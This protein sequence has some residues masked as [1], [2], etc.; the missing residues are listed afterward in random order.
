MRSKPHTLITSLKTSSHINPIQTMETDLTNPTLSSED[1]EEDVSRRPKD[2]RRL[3][4]V[5]VANTKYPVVRYVFRKILGFRLVKDDAD[6]NCDVYW[7][8]CCIDVEKL[9]RL[10][11]FQ[12]IN[13]FPGM[14]EIGRKNNLARNLNRM[15]K[16]F[17]KDYDFYPRTWQ[18][19]SE[20]PDFA[21]QFTKKHNKTF[22]VKPEA[23][24]QGR[25]IFL[26]RRLEDIERGERF[27]A[28]RYLHRP[29]LLDGLKFDL[30][31]YVLVA[32][33][34]PLRIY[35]HREGLTRL[36]TEA[37]TAPNGSNIEDMC[38]HLTNYAVNKRNP[39]FIFN[40]DEESDDVGHKRSL[41]WTL[42]FLRSKGCDVEALWSRICSMIVKTIVAIQPTLAHTYKSCHP[43]DPSNSMCFEVLGLDVFLSH[44]LKP[45]VLEVNM[46]P[47]LATDSPL[48]KKIKREVLADTMRL[49]NVTP[50]LRRTYLTKKKVEAQQRAITGRVK[51]SREERE[52]L[53]HKAQLR[54][55]KYEDKNLGG[56]QKLYPSHDRAYYD[57]FIEK[58]AEGYHTRTGIL[59]HKAFDE[60]TKTDAR[61]PTPIKPPEKPKTGCNLPEKRSERG[62][63]PLPKT[64]GKPKIAEELTQKSE[65]KP[66]TTVSVFSRLASSKA[67][68]VTSARAK[69]I[70]IPSQPVPLSEQPIPKEFATIPS[71]YQF[72]SRLGE[73]GLG[74]AAEDLLLN[75]LPAQDKQ[76]PPSGTVL[77]TKK[78][79]LMPAEPKETRSGIFAP[80]FKVKVSRLNP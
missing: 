8:D 5:N 72:L 62:I 47:S 19:P 2:S 61:L 11:P 22:I 21:A 25:G 4:S 50:K 45:Y 15:R 10:K 31:I 46:S 16:H 23:S 28:Q 35:I 9:M 36:A 69:P 78:L 58:A 30:R 60:E 59:K 51:E 40:E 29:F 32:G 17:P 48:D 14:Y 68:S 7:H 18:L 3:L 54:R 77:K 44:N 1:S 55:D 34:D 76:R 12:K 71:N 65:I 39:N 57:R 63:S 53:H 66:K 49:M 74:K 26:T 52:I 13:H 56:Y 24:C 67:R 75:R 64:A 37:Y 42:D 27:V 41:T 80:S 70:I 38:M 79:E 20:W 73:L 33:C 43:D 6:E